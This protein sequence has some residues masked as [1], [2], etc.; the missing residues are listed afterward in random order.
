MKS[1][2][3]KLYPNAAVGER[4]SSYAETHSTPLPAHIKA[5]HELIDRTRDDSFFMS[6]DLQ[7]QWHASLARIAGARRILEIGVYVGYSALVWAHA[8]GPDGH[9]TGLEFSKEY[10]ELAEQVLA[11]NGVKNA[12]IQ[13]GDALK[14]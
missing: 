14:T 12:D 7:S 5:Y 13:V 6:S 2:A 11:Q 9:V 1:N 10:A 4:V 3:T 8:V